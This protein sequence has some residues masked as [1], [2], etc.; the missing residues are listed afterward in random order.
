[1]QEL[2]PAIQWTAEATDRK[3]VMPMFDDIKQELRLISESQSLL[4]L[5]LQEKELEHC[6]D[7]EKTED[8]RS[9]NRRLS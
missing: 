9:E 7:K 8:L 1:M 6:S 2:F 4:Q 5:R 3:R